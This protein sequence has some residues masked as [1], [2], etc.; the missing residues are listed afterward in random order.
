MWDITCFVLS[1]KNAHKTYGLMEGGKFDFCIE[2]L[3]GKHIGLCVGGWAHS[4]LDIVDGINERNDMQLLHI[5]LTLPQ[6]HHP[7]LVCICVGCFG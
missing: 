2:L 5:A 7:H 3:F 4:Y 1:F 6:G